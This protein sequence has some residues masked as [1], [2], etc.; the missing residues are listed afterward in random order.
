[1]RSLAISMTLAVACVASCSDDDSAPPV[2]A[3]ADA[4]DGGGDASADSAVPPGPC[5]EL[6]LP[7]RPFVD[8]AE[9]VELRALASDLVIPTTGGD[10]SLK[11][12]WSGCEVLFFIPDTPAQVGAGFPQKL[13]E[14]PNDVRQLFQ[15]LPRNARLF[16]V[17]FLL[18][19]QDRTE[20]LA[21]LADSVQAVLTLMEPEEREWWAQRVHYVPDRVTALQGWLGQLLANPGFGLG[22]DRAQRIRFI[23]GFG[24]PTRYNASVG[25]FAP[26][27]SMVAN[28][29]IHYNAE[30]TRD[31]RLEAQAA[32]VVP[33]FDATPLAAHGS[34]PYQVVVD[35][36]EQAL[37]AAADSLELDLALTCVGP[38]EYG[39]CPAWDYDVF[40]NLCETV[41]ATSC[42]L[43]VGHWITSYHREGRWV[44]DVSGLLPYFSGGGQRK[45]SFHISDPW[46][47]TLSLR[48]FGAG[49][50][51]RP[52]EAVPLWIRTQGFDESYND[53]FPLRTVFIPGD[54]Q[55]VELVTAITGHGMSM[56]GNCAEFC[57]TEHHFLVNGQDNLQ[58]FPGAGDTYG[59]Q[60]QI[61]LG[62]VP[63]QMGTWWYGRGGWCPGKQVDH[64]ITDITEQVSLGQDNLFEYQ[65]FYL[66]QPY[67]GDNW[68]HIHLASW[69]VVSRSQGQ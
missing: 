44:H 68:R 28:E 19:Q 67:Q 31:A 25:W 35:L 63:N 4:S 29:A 46:E 37:L 23:G 30:A 50:A 26:N 45:L 64:L 54:A 55:R 65:G 57:N 20:A 59:C 24:D 10:Y 17:S 62:T 21:A 41:D 52:E 43:E 53:A 11:E 42:D 58:S 3:A 49:K 56:P 38:G 1:M 39:Y 66:G 60:D 33:L 18:G 47:V 6:G 48:F 9:L 13:W 61:P 34:G 32:T 22:V 8:T 14:V 16:F 15:R 51:L 12:S 69:V 7:A 40:L 2:D 36:P 27:L 5:E